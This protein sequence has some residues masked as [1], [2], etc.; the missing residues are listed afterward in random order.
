M[1][2]ETKRSDFSEIT[3]KYMIEVLELILKSE[4]L[5]ISN[6]LNFVKEKNEIFTKIISDGN[7]IIGR[8]V[9]F[10]KKLKEY[11]TLTQGIRG[12]LNFNELEYKTF[13]V[14]SRGYLFKLKGIDLYKAPEEVRL[15]YDKYFLKEG[16][17]LDVIVFPEEEKFVKPYYIIDVKDML[18]FA[19]KDRCDLLLQPLI[20][21]KQEILKF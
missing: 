11:K 15:N 16:K 19:W 10:G 7:T 14:G 12:M 4:T 2:I 3:K 17:K 18:E 1:G 9:S 8:P 6:V 20:N 5:S 21:L 13:D